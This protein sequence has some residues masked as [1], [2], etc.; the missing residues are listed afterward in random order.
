MAQ[1]A[2]DQSST[3]SGG[4]VRWYT[5]DPAVLD[6]LTPDG[7]AEEPHDSR[8]EIHPEG[9]WILG[10]H[11]ETS[12]EQRQELVAVLQK[13]QTTSFAYSLKDLPAY[14]GPLGPAHF[15]LKEDRPMRQSQRQY[16]AEELEVGDSKVKEM[17]EAGIIEEVPTTNKHS[18]A[19]TLPMKRA[20]DG[21]WS[22]KRFSARCALAHMACLCQS[23]C[24]SVCEGMVS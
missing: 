13:H 23:N 12:S 10:N 1:S 21:S 9:K 18:S 16:T 8:W 22:D 24:F 20:P 4:G 11:P 14:T 15:E 19:I 6:Q 7:E 5:A 17:Q 3:E 2:A